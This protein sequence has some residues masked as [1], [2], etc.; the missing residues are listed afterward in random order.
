MHPL[1]GIELFTVCMFLFVCK[2]GAA[3]QFLVSADVLSKAHCPSGL[4]GQSE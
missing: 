3:P 1:Q 2:V 4:Q